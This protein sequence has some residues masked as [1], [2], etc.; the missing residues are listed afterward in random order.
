MN[1]MFSFS[2][3]KREDEKAERQTRAR[4]ARQKAK[5]VAVV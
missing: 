2:R 1:Y 4:K 5:Y 3:N